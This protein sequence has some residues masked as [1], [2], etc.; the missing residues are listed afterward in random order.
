VCS[1]NDLPFD[2]DGDSDIRYGD[3]FEVLTPTPSPT[4]IP[5]P[6]HPRLPIS[7]LFGT[8][9]LLII[10]V[11]LGYALWFFLGYRDCRRIESRIKETIMAQLQ[12][13]YAAVP[14][15]FV[16]PHLHRMA[17]FVTGRVCHKGVLVTIDLTKR[18]DSFGFLWDAL[19]NR[20]SF[21]AF[22]FIVDPQ[23]E[24]PGLFH[25]S[26]QVP[27]FAKALQLTTYA[28]SD[29]KLKCVT[30]MD[31]HR[32]I[33]LP[34]FNRFMETHRGMLKL[35]EI[36]DV[37]RFQLMGECRF[38]VRMEFQFQKKDECFVFG[39]EIVNFAM[40]VADKFAM[41]KMDPEVTARNN[42]TRQTALM[43]VREK[44]K[45]T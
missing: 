9:E 6:L 30:D 28:V 43:S 11:F 39:P 37:N 41:M 15:R 13:Y 17:A 10:L 3:D 24:V 44:M 36:S 26:K 22:E 19:I 40:S 18:C 16:K 31:D 29:E 32:H 34:L 1:D 33:F 12:T 27:G 14:C 25:I 5:A 42:R 20:F 35:V 23:R 7:S 38:V 8:R 45:K 2:D 4:P 21:L